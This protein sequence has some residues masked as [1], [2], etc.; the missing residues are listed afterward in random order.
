MIPPLG[1]LAE[2]R[3]TP[4]PTVGV[5]LF[6]MALVAWIET[7]I[8]LHPRRQWNRAHLGPN[9]SLTFIAFTTNAFF[10]AALVVALGLFEYHRFGLMQLVALRPAIAL[11]VT[12]LVLDFA[13][14]VAHV[15]MHKIPG[16]WR[17]HRVHHSDPAVDVTTT[18]RQHPGESVIRYIF[19]APV[20]LV[21]GASPAAF[22]A[23]L[24]CSALNGLLEHANI[25]VPPWLD[26]LLSLITTWPN[27]HK[28]HH[29][30]VTTETDANYGNL[31]SFW[32][33]I[34]F[35]FTRARNATD[36][37]YGLRGFDDSS[38]QSTA[39]L[40]TTPFRHTGRE[41]PASRRDVGS[42]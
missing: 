3:A 11:A 37:I 6:M 41:D 8:P 30:C 21:L 27:M 26:T 4:I 39:A 40:L 29:S 12:V 34:F 13:F 16:F 42:V 38:K 14:Y 18:L 9:L 10:N 1:S 2:L 17:F 15:A 25:R 36:I 19:L 33:R 32:D 31:F 24:L 20:A 5:I 7:A 28:V 35:T 22:G 23:Y